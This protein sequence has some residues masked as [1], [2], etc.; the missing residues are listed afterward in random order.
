MRG[1]GVRPGPSWPRRCG[2]A[3]PL[4]LGAALFVVLAVHQ[5][6]LARTLAPGVGRAATAFFLTAVASLLALALGEAGI[7]LVLGYLG[8]GRWSRTGIIALAGLGPVILAVAAG[9]WS[10][11]AVAALAWAGALGVAFGIRRWDLGARGGDER[12]VPMLLLLLGPTTRRPA[13]LAAAP[14]PSKQAGRRAA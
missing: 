10:W 4:L 1:E 5:A 6:D 11:P 9:A 3:L 14:A 2:L 8:A 12:P 13:P 7:A